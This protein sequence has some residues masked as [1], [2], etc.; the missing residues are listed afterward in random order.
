MAALSTA[1]VALDVGGTSIRAALVTAEGRV[2]HTVTRP[3]VRAGRRDPGLAGT[4]AAARET[5]AAAAE[6]GVEVA[7]IGA[8]FP[9]YVTADGR[10]T[11]S[12]VLDW[13]S[14]PADLLAPLVPGRPVVVDSDVRCAALAEARSGRGRGHGSFLYVSVGTG[15]SA[16]F[17]QDGRPWRGHR[18]EA[19]ALGTFEVP[20]S[21]DAGFSAGGGGAAAPG[22]GRAP[23][24]LEAY[25]SGA[26]L[27][28]R[29]TH[30]TGEAVTGARDVVR[31]AAAGDGTA[32]ALLR[33][34]GLALGT[35][36]AWV[37]ALLDPEAVVIGG[38]LGTADGV[39]HDALRE[40]CTAGCRRRCPPPLHRAGLGAASGLLGAASMA[41][42]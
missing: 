38:G 16:A 28:A 20:A 5:V 2:L 18:G 36:L 31:R 6:R 19:L 26:G 37:V 39:L 15:L 4:V 27:A 24:S 40:A 10:L 8:G 35:A 33:T 9:E 42:R 13:N 7:G 11:S 32:A 29:Y 41:W 17:V 25:A 23:A 30:A 21:V 22:D 34:A 14:Q 12:E 3:T 1:V